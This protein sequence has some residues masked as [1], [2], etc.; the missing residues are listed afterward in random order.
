MP[1]DKLETTIADEIRRMETIAAWLVG[2]PPKFVRLSQLVSHE[3]TL[4]AI[5]E[6]PDP[7][8][9]VLLGRALALL[10]MQTR[11]ERQAPE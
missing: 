2:Y 7:V 5:L 1:E 4:K 10:E 3:E 9:Q 8:V 11:I 6:N